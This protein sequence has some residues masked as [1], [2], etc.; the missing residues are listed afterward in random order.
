M[1]PEAIIAGLVAFIGTLFGV[2]GYLWRLH[3]K[4]DD[5]VTKDLEAAKVAGAAALGNVAA[6]LPAVTTLT[7]AVKTVDERAEER[8][9]NIQKQSAEQH[10]AILKMLRR[11]RPAS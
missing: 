2:I 10:T 6:L 3:L 1:A 11:R 8:Y 9:T 7:E 4:D 5:Q